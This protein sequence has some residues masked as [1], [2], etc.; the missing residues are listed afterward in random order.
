MSKPLKVIAILAFLAFLPGCNSKRD[1]ADVLPNGGE[2]IISVLDQN[3]TSPILLQGNDRI[4]FR[5]PSVI[6]HNGVFYMYHSLVKTEEQNKIFW[7]IAMSKSTDSSSDR[8]TSPALITLTSPVT[9][10]PIDLAI[11]SVL[12]YTES[13]TTIVFIADSSGANST[14]SLHFNQRISKHV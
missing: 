8:F 12:P 4:A 14:A 7:Y 13:Y 3:V 6:Y 1:A 9:A 5:D 2:N 10:P 11:F